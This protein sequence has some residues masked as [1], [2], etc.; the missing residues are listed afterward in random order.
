[1]SESN[2]TKTLGV[3]FST[4]DY[5]RLEQLAEA[6]K[7]TVSEIVR[8]CIND[9][10]NGT[11]FSEVFRTEMRGALTTIRAEMAANLTAMRDEKTAQ[12]EHVRQSVVKAMG[13]VL[14]E[15]KKT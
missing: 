3:R 7:K 14:T 5:R 9:R 1:M 6:E 10:L 8:G 12:I 2:T 4:E 15:I 13:V 11:H